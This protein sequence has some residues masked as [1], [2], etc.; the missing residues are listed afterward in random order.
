MKKYLAI[1]FLSL[2]TAC[3]TPP[4][5]ATRQDAFVSAYDQVGALAHDINDAH[6]SGLVDD[7]QTLQM[8]VQLQ[9]AQDALV[10]AEKLSGAADSTQKT[11]SAKAIL[12]AVRKT[13]TDRGA[14]VHE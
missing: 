6:A 1:C 13:L 11:E 7:A 2:L 12:Q 8:K 14:K 3:V 9:K 10:E 5:I 4:P